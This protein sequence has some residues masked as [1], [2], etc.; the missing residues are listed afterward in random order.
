MFDAKAARKQR[1]D[2]FLGMFVTALM[3]DAVVIVPFMYVALT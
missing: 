1:I 2:R 3:F